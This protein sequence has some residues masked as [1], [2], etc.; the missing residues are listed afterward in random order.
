M[1][2]V[3]GG[4]PKLLTN[5]G[6]SLFFFA[7]DGTNGRELW[8]SDGTAAGTAMVKDVRP[9]NVETYPHYLTNVNGTL[10]YTLSHDRAVGSEL[11]KSD[12]TTAGTVLVKDFAEGAGFLANANGTL[13]FS[14]NDGV[15]GGEL[16]K[17]DGTAAGTTLIRDIAPGPTGSNP[18]NITN[19]GGTLYFTA[20]DAVYGKELWQ[21]DGTPLGTLLVKDILPGTGGSNP[22]ILSNFNGTLIFAADDGVHGVEPWIIPPDVIS[23]SPALVSNAEGNAGPTGFLITVSLSAASDQ[24]VTVGFATSDGDATLANNDYQATSGVL[25]FAPGE[26]TKIVTVVVIG[27]TANEPDESFSLHLL[28]SVNAQLGSATS[29][30]VIENDD[31][32]SAVVAGRYLFYNQSTYDGGSAAINASDDGAIAT[33]KTAYLPTGALAT[34]ANVSSYSRGI[35]GIM[36]DLAGAG[37]HGSISA[38]DF[39]FKVGNNNSPGAWTLAPVPATV[40][41]RAGA[42]LSGSDRVEITWAN[43]AIRNQWLEVQV[44]PNARRD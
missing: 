4:N 13:I 17:S 3:V 23:L 12:G 35:N 40:S 37:S 9:G 6:G 14:G 36:I 15:M 39:T 25:T 43:N 19:V 8:H 7:N 27:D 22:G 41:V 16:W 42:G 29:T 5:V 20:N 28:D 1:A 26:T 2:A 30:A 38:N 33:D 11:W 24:A 34:F 21:S 44:L 31:P 32:L 10:Y 18:N